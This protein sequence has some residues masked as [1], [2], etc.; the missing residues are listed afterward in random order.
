[1]L[2]RSRVIRVTGSP[3][4]IVTSAVP[5]GALNTIESD[6][7]D[8][9]T[10]V[11]GDGVADTNVVSAALTDDGVSTIAAAA[12]PAARLSTRRTRVPRIGVV[13]AFTT[14]QR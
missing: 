7:G 11:F 1:M 8:V 4:V 12:R 13:A 6:A 5:T 2:F 9:W 14:A 10:P 3:Q